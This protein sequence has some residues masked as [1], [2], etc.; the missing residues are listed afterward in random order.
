MFITS[1]NPKPCEEPPPSRG[2]TRAPGI[3][4]GKG[5][6]RLVPRDVL[7]QGGQREMTRKAQNIPSVPNPL[8]TQREGR[9]SLRHRSV[10]A[11]AQG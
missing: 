6:I 10:G 8:G 11:G 7:G 2:T 9:W 5:N 3:C 1:C 4:A